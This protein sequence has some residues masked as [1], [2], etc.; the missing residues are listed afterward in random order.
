M[1]AGIPLLA[2][3]SV[4]EGLALRLVR[5]GGVAE[6]APEDALHVA[7]AAV[8]GVDYL[9]T[10]NCKHIAN[11]RTRKAMQ[12]VVESAG[13]SMPVVCTPEEITEAGC[14]DGSDR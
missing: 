4:A 5:A 14:E 10:W 1:L 11:A 2:V 8:N 3:S 6:Q 13:Y 7:V 9:V 12:A